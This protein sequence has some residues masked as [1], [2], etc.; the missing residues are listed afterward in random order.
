MNPDPARAL[1]ITARLAATAALVGNCEALAARRMF[2]YAGVFHI[3]GV[4]T[5]HWAD[6]RLLAVLGGREMQLLCLGV[7]SCLVA[8]ILGPWDGIGYTGLV[9]ALAVRLAMGQRRI[10]GSDG[11]EQLT[12]LVLVSVALAAF[13]PVSPTRTGLAVG[14][15]AAQL[16]LCYTTSGVS[17]LASPVWRSGTAVGDIIGTQTYGLGVAARAL[18]RVPFGSLGVGWAV[19]L[20][21]TAFVAA[22][23]G[24]SWL[25]LGALG[26]ALLFHVCCAVVMGLNDFLWAFPATYPCVLVLSQ[27]F[28]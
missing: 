25:V 9:T 13:P 20:F 24:P 22:L 12:T 27:W 17:K 16:V 5:L 3:S 8:V 1:D 23:F 6:S 28:R 19:M 15:I 10:V 18:G 11:A 2:R 7:L 21:E 26:M 4:R 14:F